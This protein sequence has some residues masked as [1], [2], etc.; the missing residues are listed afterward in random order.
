MWV[1]VVK[2]GRRILA[3]VNNQPKIKR[4]PKGVP[5]IA[6]TLERL[7]QVNQPTKKEFQV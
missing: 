1:V 5:S 3:T 6:A 2:L 7:G 4:R